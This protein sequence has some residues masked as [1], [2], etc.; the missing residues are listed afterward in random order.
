M[1][2]FPL[3]SFPSLNNFSI[4]LIQS[5]VR[6]TAVAVGR[7]DYLDGYSLLLIAKDQSNLVIIPSLEDLGKV[8][9]YVDRV[10]Y[11]VCPKW[12]N[13]REETQFDDRKSWRLYHFSRKQLLNLQIRTLLE[14]ALVHIKQYLQREAGQRENS[15][16]VYWI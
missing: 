7:K 3:S 12:W 9:R 5:G 6:V 13:F 4:F 1:Q 8:E 14:F 16:S 10:A 11:M 2:Q 15:R